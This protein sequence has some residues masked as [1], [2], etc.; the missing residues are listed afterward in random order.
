MRK[1]KYTVKMIRRKLLMNQQEFADLIGVSRVS[2]MSWE[3]GKTAPNTSNKKKILEV[4]GLKID[5]FDDSFFMP[6]RSTNVD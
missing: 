2:V 1:N 4:S 5:D 6:V 3:T